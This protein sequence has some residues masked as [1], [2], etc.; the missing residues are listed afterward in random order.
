MPKK[1]PESINRYDTDIENGLPN[2]IIE[3]RILEAKVKVAKIVKDYNIDLIAIGNGT[4]S[5]ETEEFIANTIRDYNLPCQF[6]IV[7]EAGASVYS[8]SDLAREEF[9]EYSVEER[10]AVSISYLFA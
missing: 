1:H 5:R 6:I 10:S 3:K 4:A 8:A 2:E 9:P 7:S